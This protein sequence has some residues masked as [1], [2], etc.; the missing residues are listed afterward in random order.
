MA[1]LLWGKVYYKSDFAGYLHEEPGDRVTFTYDQSYIESNLPAIA[2]TLPL[3]QTPHISNNGLH[4]F[5]DNLV[6]EGWLEQAQTRLLGKRSVSRFELL[7]TFGFDCAGAV[8]VIDPEPFGLSQTM[9]DI[10]DAKEMATLTSR[11]SLSGVQPK[12]AILEQNGQ[13]RPS[14]V[15]ELSTHIAKFPS[16]EHPDILMNEYLTTRAFQA[17]LPDDEVVELDIKEV[18]GIQEEALVIKRFD[19]K[20]NNRIHFEEFNQLLNFKSQEKYDGAYKDMSDFIYISKDCIPAQSYILYRRIMAGILLGNTDMHLKNFSMFNL[21]KGYRLTPSY[22]QV[23]AAL[24]QYKT[25]ALDI[26]G[27]KDLRISNLKARNL[28]FLGEEFKL[29]K[30]AI[31]MA[32]KQLSDNLEKAKDAIA[33]SPYGINP[34]KNKLINFMEKR[35]NGTYDLIGQNLLKK[36]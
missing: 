28:I 29:P 30:G 10:S 12:L 1:R 23:A 14:K 5:F 4:P 21:K 17:L 2:Y 15:N 35:W 9:L 36:L 11:A 32:A 22:D 16:S 18:Q 20:D 27:A 8:S 7:L 25:L 3:Q 34:L 19:R 24:Y 6:S 26:H 13:Y 33:E 31:N